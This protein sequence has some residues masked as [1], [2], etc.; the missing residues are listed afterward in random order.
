MVTTHRVDLWHPSQHSQMA[1]LV[2]ADESGIA[3]EHV[4]FH[5]SSGSRVGKLE[6]QT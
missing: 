3:P 5:G 6:A 1:Y 4:Y 2:A